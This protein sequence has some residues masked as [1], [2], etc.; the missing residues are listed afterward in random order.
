MKIVADT[1]IPFLKGVLEPYAEVLYAD[2]RSI[3][4]AL[5]QDADALIIRTRTKCNEE[6]LSGSR[7]QMI[8]SAT[9]GTDHIDIVPEELSA[10]KAVSSASSVSAMWGKRWSRWRGA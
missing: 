3:D 7:V 4:R 5:I 1:N 2:G 8:A 6:T 10:W 9:I